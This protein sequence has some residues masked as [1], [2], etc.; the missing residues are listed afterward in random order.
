[1][2]VG[3][4]GEVGRGGGPRRRVHRLGEAEI[5]DLD[6]ALGREL[7]VPGL[8]V[9]VDDS[10]LVSGLERLGDLAGDGEDLFERE[11][12][13]LQPL[14][15]ILSLDELHDEGADTARLLEAV[16]RGDVGV[17]QLGEELRFALEARETLGVGGE[18]LGQDLDRDLAPELRVGRPVDDPHPALAERAGDLVGSE[19]AS[20]RETHRVVPL[21]FSPENQSST[22][23]MR[24]MAGSGLT[25]WMRRKREPSLVML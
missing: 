23:S 11:G 15:E 16:D 7:D 18:C 8:E 1:M 20:G 3:E 17:L 5:E 24:L 9:P 21:L 10:L 13:A 14:G 19:A 2:S 25:G 12:A 4:S 6:L 22:S